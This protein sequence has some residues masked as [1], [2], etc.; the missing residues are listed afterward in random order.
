MSSKLRPCYL[1]VPPP[2]GLAEA[3]RARRE[4]QEIDCGA[5]WAG[6]VVSSRGLSRR[7]RAHVARSSTTGPI[8]GSQIFPVREA[9]H[10]TRPTS[11]TCA[12]TPK[13]NAGSRCAPATT[14]KRSSCTSR[15]EGSARR[16]IPVR[17]HL[18][19]R[20]TRHGSCVGPA[21]AGPPHI[22]GFVLGLVG[23]VS[24]V[25]RAA[26]QARR[27]YLCC[28]GH[29]LGTSLARVGGVARGR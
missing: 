2:S 7:D 22:C 29:T 23:A 18:P 24:A 9:T 10:A 15:V 25:G 27:V 5:N 17:S 4:R 20:C 1:L 26:G 28:E 16:P 8:K 21:A 3:R 13:Y 12:S 14:M 6:G 19:E 11:T